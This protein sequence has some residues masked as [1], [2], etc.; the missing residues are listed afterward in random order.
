[1]TAA[2]CYAE[3]SGMKGHWDE[4]LHGLDYL[5]YAYLQ[6]GKDE[7]AKEQLEYLQSMESVFPLNNKDAYTFAA[8]PT[9]YALERKN[10]DEAAKLELKPRDFPWEN[11]PWEKSI[12][13]FGRVL[14][15]VHNYRLD[16]AKADLANL[17]SSYSTLTKQNRTYEANQVQIQIKAA[18]AWIQFY[19]GH[20]EEAIKRMTEAA[21]MEDATDKHPVTPGEVLP[22]RELLGD[23]F[24]EMKDFAKALEAYEEDLKRHPGRFNGLYG[25]GL[26]A[27]KLGRTEKATNFFQQLAATAQL[28][29]KKRPEL[30]A[31]ELYLKERI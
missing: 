11:F 22:A 23:M 9:R 21:T 25:A 20:K 26:A 4:E 29:D 15:A 3:N 31:A 30:A 8:V 24:M 6:Q 14:G 7:M 19:Q 5:V 10:W 16:S 12:V 17:Q 2:K 1:M 28:T 27:K 18:E 13:S